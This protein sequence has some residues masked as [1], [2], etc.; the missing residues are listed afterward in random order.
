MKKTLALIVLCFFVS[1]QTLAANLPATANVKPNIAVPK[2]ESNSSD[3]ITNGG[4]AYRYGHWLFYR[5]PADGNKLYKIMVDGTAKTKICSLSC[6]YINASNGWVY[7]V[8]CTEGSRSEVLYKIKTDG[9]K[10]TKIITTKED[11]ITYVTVKGNWIYYCLYSDLYRIGI[12]GKGK[13]LVKKFDESYPINSINITEKDIFLTIDLDGGA[14]A[15]N[16]S[17]DGK[18]ANPVLGHE[19]YQGDLR[20]IRGTKPGI[21]PM[22]AGV[23]E[24]WMYYIDTDSNDNLFRIKANGSGDAYKLTDSK[25]S[26]K[27]MA[28]LN[29]WIYYLASIPNE[30]NCYLFKIRVDGKDCTKIYESKNYIED[31]NVIDDFIYLIEGRDSNVLL[32]IKNDG[33]IIKEIK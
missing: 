22:I 31:F 8:N 33:S 18:K 15:Y 19:E 9:S 16:L 13:K 1:S 25:Y 23:N 14:A 12:D 28:V 7:F 4:I 3:N 29:G 26:I 11:S 32:K 5:N 27:S 6:S 20:T 10:L 17:L 2:L 30:E 21:S 24:G